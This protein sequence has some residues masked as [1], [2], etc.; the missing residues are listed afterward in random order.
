MSS[1]PLHRIEKSFHHELLDSSYAISSNHSP[2]ISF[3]NSLSICR[4]VYRRV[5]LVYVTIHW[6]VLTFHFDDGSNRCIGFFLHHTI[7]YTTSNSFTIQ[8]FYSFSVLSICLSYT[9]FFFLLSP[10]PSALATSS[11]YR[12]AAF[13][14]FPYSYFQ[15]QYFISIFPLASVIVSINSFKG[16]DQSILKGRTIN[17]YLLTN[18]IEFG[19]HSIRNTSLHQFN[20]R[21]CMHSPNGNAI[22]AREISSIRW[23]C[24]FS[25]SSSHEGWAWSFMCMQRLWFQRYFEINLLAVMHLELIIWWF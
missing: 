19:L 6:K 24:N 17:C 8:V 3:T 9:L 12:D 18:K 13:N 20:F 14:T 4:W 16:F 23:A 11:L 21:A 22:S 2:I 25:T 7:S 10:V 5:F 1:S 15:W